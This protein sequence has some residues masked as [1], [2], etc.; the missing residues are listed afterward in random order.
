M[1]T[2][3]LPDLGE[4]LRDAEI[5]AWH[6]GEGDRVIADQPLLAVE[7][8]KAVVEV[9]APWSGRIAKIHGAPGDVIEIGAPLVEFDIDA[10]AEDKGAVVGEL[11]GAGRPVG[12]AKQKEPHE[13]SGAVQRS[14]KTALAIRALALERGI[15]LATIKGTGP[16]G[17]ITR[18]DVAAAAEALD[19]EGYEPL[20]GVRRSMARNMAHAQAH[21]AATTITDEALV[22]HWAEGEDVT[23]RLVRALIAACKAEPALNAWYDGERQARRLHSDIHIGI[24]MNTKDGLFVPVLS[25]AGRIGD[26]EEGR[27]R[28]VSAPGSIAGPNDHALQFRHALGALCDAHHHAASGRHSWGRAHHGRAARLRWR[29]PGLRCLAAVTH[30]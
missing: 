23:M 4:G 22:L 28:A 29:N 15:D 13:K 19:A 8:E 27:C 2:F 26:N 21:V 7:T 17:A 12:A 18:A 5:V 10:E 11:P 24:A 1:K 3:R 25:D 9:P 14:I 20:R 16:Y 6:V 30:V